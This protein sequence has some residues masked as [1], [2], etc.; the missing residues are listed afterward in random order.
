VLTAPA[1]WDQRPANRDGVGNATFYAPF[2]GCTVF[3]G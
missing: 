2:R 1:F 3:N